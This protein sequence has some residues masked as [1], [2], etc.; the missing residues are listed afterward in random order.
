[1]LPDDR[2]WVFINTATDVW[3]ISVWDDV[4]INSLPATRVGVGV[5]MLSK[6]DVK[7]VI[8]LAINLELSVLFL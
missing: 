1:M 7:V 6:L 5:S 3:S 4:L 8:A 2:D